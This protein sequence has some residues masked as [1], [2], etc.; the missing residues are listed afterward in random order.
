MASV[1]ATRMVAARAWLRNSTGVLLGLDEGR[2]RPAVQDRIHIIQGQ[3][4]HC[5]TSFDRGA[6]D[7]RQQKCIFQRNI[8]RVKFWLAFKYVES[9]SGDPPALES[10]D[11][12]V[13]DHQSAASR[14]HDDSPGGQKAY[15]FGVQEMV[16]LRSLRGVQ[17]QELTYAKQIRRILVVDGIACN[18]RR[19]GRSVGIVNLHSESSRSTRYGL[20]HVPHSQN[21]ED[22]TTDLP[23]E[24]H[25]GSQGLPRSGSNQ[26]LS[27]VSS[28]RS[29]EQ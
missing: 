5:C 22:F 28:T 8:F 17:A 25:I 10:G 29:T 7:M 26:F 24:E 16:G 11:E 23:S 1:S 3:H 19:Q 15:G 6:A 20:S 14:V 27:F 18:F 12:V 9:G 2:R 4:A 21:A 13:V